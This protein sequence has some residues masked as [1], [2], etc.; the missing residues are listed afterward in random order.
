MYS[1]VSYSSFAQRNPF[2]QDFV[3]LTPKPRKS[4]NAH[5]HRF[6]PGV[7]QSALPP[8]QSE[9]NLRDSSPIRNSHAVYYTPPNLPQTPPPF[10]AERS[11]STYG[12][13]RGRSKNR[14][15][16]EEV[17][18]GQFSSRTGSPV[19]QV[20]RSRS[21]VKRLLGLGKST[22]TKEPQT[23]VAAEPQTP[24]AAS[25]TKKSSLKQWSD[26]FRHGFL[27]S[28]DYNNT[29]QLTSRRVSIK[30]SSSGRQTS[31]NTWKILLSLNRHRLFPFHWI[32]PTKQD[33][34]P[35]SNS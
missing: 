32:R 24:T 25:S 21:P 14:E 33:Y 4:M 1:L 28:M 15:P 19:K 13:P 3:P 16:A 20:K 29:A 2:T 12:S 9:P 34:K 10:I 27:V 8:S 23:G 30:R 17:D 26:K 7:A 5:E 22:P 6:H 31:N 35:M 11:R 18:L